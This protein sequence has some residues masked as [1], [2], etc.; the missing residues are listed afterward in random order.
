[1]TGYTTRA[2]HPSVAIVTHWVHLVTLVALTF[3]GFWI[4]YPFFDASFGAMRTIHLVA[5]LFF[6]LAFLVRMGWALVRATTAPGG[7][8][9]VR[10]V[11]WFLP[12]KGDVK[13]GFQTA[14]YYLFLRKTHP[15]ALKYNPMQKMAYL[16]LI[17]AFIAVLI[18][19]LQIWQKTSGFFEPLTYWMGGPMIVRTIHYGCMWLFLLI[20]VVHLYLA[21]A[22]TIFE[23]PMMFLGRSRAIEHGK[24]QR[25]AQ[26]VEQPARPAEDDAEL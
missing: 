15:R 21:V 20:A 12:E 2:E 24:R 7:E 9:K 6:S 22:E 8:Q 13:L 5:A 1:M 10:D 4:H 18:T 26:L 11:R 25:R 14:K 19:G 17:P 16:V 3:T 23:V